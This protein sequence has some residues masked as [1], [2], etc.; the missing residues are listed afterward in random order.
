MAVKI[1]SI[2]NI[3]FYV[4]RN[5]KDELL[6]LHSVVGTIHYHILLRKCSGTQ[7]PNFYRA[8]QF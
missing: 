6:Q 3:V 5:P 1:K 8:G 7:K 4:Y 2:V